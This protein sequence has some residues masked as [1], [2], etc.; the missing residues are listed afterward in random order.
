MSSDELSP[1]SKGGDID[2]ATADVANR[3]R[4]TA[5][6]RPNPPAELNDWA[7]KAER[8]MFSRPIPPN[9]ILEPA[10]FDKEEWTTPHSDPALWTLQLADAFGTRS[11]AVISL[12]MSQLESLCGRGIWDEG[13][14]Q[15]RM[16]ESE[17]SAILAL[18]NAFRPKNE[19]EAMLAAQ[20]VAT[21]LLTMKVGARALRYEY[22]TR[23]AASY[24]KLAKAFAMQT[25][26]MQ[27]LKGR[28]RTARQSIKVTR[29]SHH[30]QH[31]HVHRGPEQNDGQSQA[32]RDDTAAGI[33][34]QR[35]AVRREDTGNNV[36]PLPMREGQ[37]P[38]PDA[39]R[40]SGSAQG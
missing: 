35:P 2:P 28:K 25:D 5:R 3:P 1:I 11:S 20:M 10:G 9:I 26:A 32:R 4:R 40:K 21:H 22:D 29:E 14:H 18:V 27:G 38:L 6:D 19:P 17:M 30:H 37:E 33:I 7:V 15:W 23:T 16:Q 31:I 13:A 8:R 12:F 39:R 24:A 36:L 34:D